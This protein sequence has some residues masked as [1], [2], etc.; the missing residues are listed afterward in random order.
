MVPS[1]FGPVAFAVGPL[2]LSIS[3]SFKPLTLAI[4]FLVILACTSSTVRGWVRA[5]SA[6][7]FYV[8]ATM[9]MFTLALGPTARTLARLESLE[10]HANAV[11]VRLDAL[12]VEAGA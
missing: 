5:R 4:V 7:G 8:I 2:R 6:F 3:D 12:A 11:T 1:L 10:A 9:A